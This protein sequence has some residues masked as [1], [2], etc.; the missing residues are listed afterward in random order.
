MLRREHKTN[1]KKFLTMVVINL[2]NDPNETSH[3][4][5][6]D[7]FEGILGADWT[8]GLD[9]VSWVRSQRD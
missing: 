3:K 5:T 2:A 8:E 1:N 4:V 7:D 6:I 9:S